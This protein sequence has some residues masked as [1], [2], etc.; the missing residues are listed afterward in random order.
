MKARN[1]FT[2]ILIIIAFNC[3]AHNYQT[4]FTNRV[5]LFENPTKKIIA[6]RIDS[7]Q[8]TQDTIFYPF[9]ILQEISPEGCSS[10]Y[11]SSWIG[12]KVV[13]KPDGTNLF[14]NRAGDTIML[15][16]QAALNES[17][18][19]FHRSDT[20]RIEASV[21]KLEQQNVP[22]LVDSVKTIGFRVID[23]NGNTINHALNSIVVKISRKRGFIQTLNFYL[24]PDI[25]THYPPDMLETYTLVGLTNPE[26]GV[27]NLTWFEV[28]DFNIGDEIHVLEHRNYDVFSPLIKEYDNKCI[29]KYLERS[30]YADSIVYSFER[31]QRIET[32]YTDSTSLE[33]YNDTLTSVVTANPD[34][35]KLPGEPVIDTFSA[36]SFYMLNDNIL[37][38]IDQS[39]TRSFV[40]GENCWSLLVGDGC[41]SNKSYYK[42]LGG[43]YYSCTGYVGE[44]EERKLVYYKKGE[45]EWG[46]KLVITDAS[47]LRTNDELE[48]FPNPAHGMVTFH[49][50]Q[51]SRNCLVQ[52]YS[53][54]G[55]L[56]R[57]C[58]FENDTYR[59]N[60]AGLK[61]GIYFY[62]LSL[63]NGRSFSGKLIVN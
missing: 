49:L 45:T 63:L 11:K 61:I 47:M 30:D 8:I 29:I 57:C 20:F 37:K 9:T 41:T 52:V 46:E 48:V 5:A 33:I 36:Y 31:Q 58:Q 23:A 4:I 13:V 25:V 51:N 35:D 18:I 40:S 54:T 12:E 62:K 53:Q 17:W 27:Q 55:S 22:G 50:N 10:P 15:K 28:Y 16:T 26:A 34:F 32:F 1:F 39:G 24:F 21:K 7:V 2:S 38:K 42:G 59:L 3:Q 44:S 60:L 14:F 19:A 43:P 56:I 6:L